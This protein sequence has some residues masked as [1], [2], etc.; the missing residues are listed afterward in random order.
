M[1]D[2][3]TLAHALIESL[4]A[5]LANLR[6]LGPLNENKEVNPT[7]LQNLAAQKFQTKKITPQAAFFMAGAYAKNNR[8]TAVFKTYLGLVAEKWGFSL[9]DALKCLAIYMV[10]GG[11]KNQE[12]TSTGLSRSLIMFV[13]GEPNR[14][15]KPI[16]SVGI[17]FIHT[18]V[19]V[20]TTQVIEINRKYKAAP[21]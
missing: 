6:E 10:L 13:T 7:F 19:Q 16:T 17:Y 14:A 21:P 18:F 2:P 8:M 20:M 9:Q 5:N 11:Y 15:L 3:K 4:V 12:L 1:S